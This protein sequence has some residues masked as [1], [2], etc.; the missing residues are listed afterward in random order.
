MMGRIRVVVAALVLMLGSSA[1]AAGYLKGPYLQSVSDAGITIMWQAQPSAAARITLTGPD[2]ARRIIEEPAA[3][4]HAVVVQGLA[5]GRRYHYQ[6]D[7]AASGPASGEFVTAPVPGADEGFSFIVFGDTRSNAAE[8]RVVVDRIRREVPDFIMHTGDITEKGAVEADWQLFFEVEHDLLAEN[9][10]FPA[11]G[12]HDRGGGGRAEGFRRYFRVPHRE[13]EAASSRYYAFTYGNSRFLVLDSTL[14]SFALTDQTAWLE[15]ELAA[16]AG[17]P[18]VHH[19]FVLMHH[20]IYSTSLHGGNVELRDQWGALFEKFHVRVVF[21][22][23]DHTYEHSFANGVHYVVSGGG[24]AAVYPRRPRASTI[25]LAASRR[26]ERVHN[27]V[28]VQ[29]IGDFVEIAAMRD[30]GSLIEAFAV[31]EL[32]ELRQPDRPVTASL[33]TVPPRLPLA[34]A[35]PPATGGCAVAAR[36]TARPPLLILLGLVL[37][38]VRRR[39]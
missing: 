29:V 32:P 30:D 15:R 24:G 20:P 10:F 27:F 35:L 39:R 7:D 9:P 1:L 37:G 14:A 5:A 6:V 13:G 36:G 8:H 11:L 17:D 31:G 38:L 26:F 23:H 18:R 33:A 22:G 28:R 16:A 2:G 34:A 21:S 19:L 4:L 3:D 25:D 12:N